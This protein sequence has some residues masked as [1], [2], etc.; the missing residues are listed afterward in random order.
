M[1]NQKKN[2][3][4]LFIGLWVIYSSAFS[5][6]PNVG[7]WNTFSIE[8]ELSK[9]FSVGLDEEIRLQDDYSRLNLLYTNVGVS[10]KPLKRLKIGLTYRLIEKLQDDKFNFRH[11]LMLDLSYKYKI[12]WLTFYYRSRLQSEIKDFNSTGQEKKPEWFW[13]NKFEIKYLFK[14]KYSP[15]CGVEFRYQI[16]NPKHPEYDNGWRRARLF[17]G[18]DYYI[19]KNNVIG[20][21]YLVQREYNLLDKNNLNIL[22]IQY[23][24]TLP[25]KQK[26][27]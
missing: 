22:G 21:Y 16:K 9:K 17:G 2:V 7:L 14:N 26:N 12:R 10:Y 1:I 4:I 20:L 8:K 23:S 6:S 24:L 25:Y 18:L 19:N 27:M 15:N 3:L 13:R 11:R 5:Q